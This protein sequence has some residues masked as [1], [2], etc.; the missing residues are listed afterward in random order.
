MNVL[1]LN[2]IDDIDG[3]IKNNNIRSIDYKYK[4]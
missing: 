2:G 4:T 1:L 3:Y